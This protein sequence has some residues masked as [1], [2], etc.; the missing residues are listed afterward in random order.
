MLRVS[1]LIVLGLAMMPLWQAARWEIRTTKSNAI[2]VSLRHAA[3]RAVSRTGMHT[4]LR[5]EKEMRPHF[6]YFLALTFGSIGSI[7]SSYASLVTMD[8]TSYIGSRQFG[9]WR[10]FLRLPRHLLSVAIRTLPTSPIFPLWEQTIPKVLLDCTLLIFCKRISLQEP[11]ILSITES[12]QEGWRPK[13]KVENLTT[14]HPATPIRRIFHI[15]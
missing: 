13:T 7:T 8:C 15:L 4:F 10:L 6:F 5:Q 12:R 2:F 9:L 3:V 11:T 1:S 14:F